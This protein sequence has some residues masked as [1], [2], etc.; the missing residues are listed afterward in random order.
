M[1]SVGLLALLACLVLGA[2]SQLP[3]PPVQRG[4]VLKGSR[5]SAVTV[6]VF[7]DLLCPDSKSNWPVM[8]ALLELKSFTD[9]ELGIV[10]NVF[11]LPYHHHAAYV[12]TGFRAF[13][14]LGSAADR[15]KCI[16]AVFEQQDE[17]KTKA[18]EL[19]EAELGAKIGHFFT[20]E[21]SCD[22]SKAFTNATVHELYRERVVMD[23]KY[24]AARTVSGTPYFTV[25]GVMDNAVGD[26][27]SADQW[28]NYVKRL[29]AGIPQLSL[30]SR[31]AGGQC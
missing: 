4:Y 6:E 25:N 16:S 29:L 20:G 1:K 7:Y 23:W 3:V 27:V 8:R 30:S 14:D 18:A 11:P 12:A 9:A 17:F 28:E 5:A 24:A 21:C 2:Y 22:V 19:G 26:F 15:M 31:R 10:M 13:W